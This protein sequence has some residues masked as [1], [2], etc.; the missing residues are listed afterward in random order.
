MDQLV[1]WDPEPDQ[2]F[3]VE[4]DRSLSLVAMGSVLWTQHTFRLAW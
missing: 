1:E 2:S 4:L 3:L